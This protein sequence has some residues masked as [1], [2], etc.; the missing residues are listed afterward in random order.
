MKCKAT[1]TMD[2][3]SSTLKDMPLAVASKQVNNGDDP[4][5][6][7][8]LSQDPLRIW[9]PP[10][11]NPPLC[12]PKISY[13]HAN[14]L[15]IETCGRW[16]ETCFAFPSHHNLRGATYA[17]SKM[18]AT[19]NTEPPRQAT[20]RLE[21]I[22]VDLL[23]VSRS[24]SGTQHVAIVDD[25]SHFVWLKPLATKS[26]ATCAQAYKEIFTYLTVQL[27]PGRIKRLRSDKGTGE[28]MSGQVRGDVF[29][30]WGIQHEP[31]PAHKQ[32][33][34]GVVERP[35]IHTEDND[36]GSTIPGQSPP[37]RKPVS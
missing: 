1:P 10:E 33:I 8:L 27:A 4:L 22:Y 3:Q 32:A 12:N 7:P 6:L 2:S 25:F 23:T 30:Q 20:E 24:L 31:A 37:R 34:N 16:H 9:L 26:A 21:Q 11:K 29:A 19:P 5:S 28:F 18:T 17:V 36:V 15:A 13:N 14:C 35:H